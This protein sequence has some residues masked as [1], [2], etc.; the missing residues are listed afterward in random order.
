MR[1]GYVSAPGKGETDRLLSG[2]AEELAAAGWRLSG[3]VKDLS[4]ESAHANSCDMVVRV[5]HSGERI[6]ITQN[7][8]PGSGA[9]RLDPGA[10]ADATA[11]V[12]DGPL[13]L[14]ALLIINKF[15]PE[16]AAG[17]GFVSVIGR[18]LN[19]DVPVL[20]GVGAGL[21]DAFDAFVCGIAEPVAPNPEALRDWAR[22]A[23]PNACVLRCVGC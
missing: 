2:L 15:G 4:H 19:A 8:G 12:E 3:I 21:R 11:R 9:C 16:E 1:V 18:A 13:E 6:Q 10:V 22:S 23:R 20:I 14:S 17:R 7:L 5:L